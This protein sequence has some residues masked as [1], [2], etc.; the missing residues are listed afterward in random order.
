MANLVGRFDEGT[1][2]VVVANDPEFEGQAGL[3]G[4]AEAG[5]NA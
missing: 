2:H 5:R 3:V 4:V 1:P